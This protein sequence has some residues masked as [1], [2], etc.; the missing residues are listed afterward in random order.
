[1]VKPHFI[2]VTL[3]AQGHLNPCLQ[4][5]KRLIRMDVQVTFVISIH[6]QR[7]ISRNNFQTPDG[8]KFATYSDGY[9][10][11][12]KSG[13]DMNH[14]FSVTRSNSSQRL[15]DII[16]TSSEEG[17]PVTCLVYNLL[18]PWA[19]K[20]ARDC[21]ICS[22]V[23]WIQPA[24]VLDIYHYYFNGYKDVIM[25][26]YKDPSWS[27]E[28]PGLPL[29]HACDLPSLLFPST[30]NGYHSALPLFEELIQEL[31]DSEAQILVNTF[32]AL[33]PEAMKVVEKYKCI[34]IGPL[35]STAFLG[36]K[37]P[38]DTS[39]VCDLFQKT[40]DY[41]E[42]LDEKPKSSVVYVSFGSLLNLP[43]PQM[44]EI[45]RG[46]LETH[47]PFLWVIRAKENEEEEKEEDRLSCMEELEQ[48][49]K[50]VPWCSQLEI[51]SHPSLGCFVT[52][53]GWSS[54]LESLA[55]GIP[56]V[57]FPHLSDQRTNAKMMV[58]VWKIGVRVRADEEGI[59]R[60]DEVKRCIEM[61]M[62]GEEI[63]EEMR[64]NA[65]KWEGL[66]REAGKEGGSSDE[67]LKAFVGEVGG[68][69]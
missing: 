56:V 22:S 28:F 38:L 10:E 34:A 23:L 51:L 69:N 11:G 67:N 64:R 15:R 3:P 63:G 16:A 52:H 65:K 13:Y 54:T 27:I 50:I 68:D 44:E 32:D 2:I 25:E 59:V 36:R 39:L 46:L 8:F 49:G 30:P 21:H 37:D 40:K 45:A 29:L 53:C 7:Q 62:R 31:N 5:A 43:Q 6:A 4:L 41:T 18:F 26:N 47:Q 55:S 24:M 1:M 19:A 57:A 33:E 17:C 60:S 66:A 35:I 12:R 58:D 42:W 20:V 48:Q 9:D 14:F 61:V